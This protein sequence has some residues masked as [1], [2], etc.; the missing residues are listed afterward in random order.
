MPEHADRT[1]GPRPDGPAEEELAALDAHWRAA[2]YLAAG[3]IYLLSNPLLT[4]PLEPEHIKPRLLGHWG[5]SPGLNLVHTH[6]NRVI[7]ARGLDAVCVWGPGHGGPAVLANSWLEGSYSEVYPDVGR[8]ADG[9]ERLFRQ[10][11]F[12]GGVPSHVAPETPGSLHEG[13]ELGYSL[14]HAYGA[15]LDNPGLLVA[16]VIGD[17]EA[18]TGPLATSW[19]AN[20]FLDP[21]HDGAVLPILHLNGYK[22]DN[23]AVLSRLP[24]GELD[25]LLRGY[26]HEPIHVTGDDPAEVHRALAHAMDRALDHIALAQRAAREEGVTDRPHWPVIVLRTPKGWTGPDEV[27]G[28]PVEGTWR[29]H[30]VPL[31]GVRDNPDHLRQLER[32]LRSYRP[33]ELFDEEGRPRPQVL[34]HVPEGKRR[35]GASPHANGGLLTRSLPLP[36]LEHYAVPVD[37]PGATLHEPTRVLGGLLAQ[38]M[39]DTAGSRNFRVVGPDET[40]SNRLDALYAATGKAWQAAE[41][42]VDEHLAHDGRVMEVL[43]EHL[44]QGWLEGYTLTGRHG[45]F[46]CYEAFVHIVDSMVNQHIKWLRTARTLPWRRPVPSLNYLLTSHVWRQDHNGFSHQDPGFVDHVLNKSPEVVR[47]YL[48]PDA[49]TL[50]SVADHVLRSR[51][52]VNVVVAGKQPCFDWL[53]LDEARAHCA[54]GAGIWEWAGTENGDRP[55]DV[56]LACAGDVPTQEVLAAADL[57]R[58]ELPQLAVRVVNVVDMTRLLPREEH[59]HGMTDAEFDA[60]F[61]TDRPVVFAYHGYPWLIHRLAYRRAGHANLHVRGYKEAGTTTTPFDMVVRNDLDRYRLVMDVVDRVP[62]LGV[63]AASVRQAMADA[64]TRHHAWIREHGVDMPEV[65]DWSWPG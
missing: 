33:E 15:A 47:V 11:S 30:Q 28:L 65:A 5:T 52:Y 41:L 20:K 51:D 40:T 27:D 39:A 35:L 10:F 58:H 29:S 25:R 26:G 3:Q 13:G 63:R 22:I 57:L 2:N 19:H 32:W 59:P 44:C 55:P 34:A 62:G 46:S 37:K 42:P 54:R 9:M 50:L 1:A 36:P 14:A 60:L 24:E 7:K 56:V 38:I 6:L 53:G 45:L 4:V 23:P 17:G 49:N 21:V 64:R 48:P 43:S 18:E 8:D 12:P 61:T 16:C 31:A